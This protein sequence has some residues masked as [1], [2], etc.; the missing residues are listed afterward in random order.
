M[1]VIF[2]LGQYRPVEKNAKNSASIFET[3]EDTGKPKAKPVV[4]IEAKKSRQAKS[5]QAGENVIEVSKT[6]RI[7]IQACQETHD[8]E[9]VKKYFSENGI[10][11]E[12]RKIGNWYYLI[13]CRKI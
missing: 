12:I 1:L 8:L 5:S 13:T 4:V 3:P 6:N 11:T 10:E 7:V 2:R 9:P